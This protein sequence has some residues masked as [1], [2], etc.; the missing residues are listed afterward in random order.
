MS[1]AKRIRK[2]K[3][4]KARD[5]RHAAIVKAVHDAPGP[6]HFRAGFEPDEQ[7]P[8]RVRLVSID[9]E[10]DPELVSLALRLLGEATRGSTTGGGS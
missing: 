4:A 6:A 10:G 9:I 5:K 7:A 3:A 2:A 8:G 1:A